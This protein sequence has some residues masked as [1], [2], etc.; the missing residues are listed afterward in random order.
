MGWTRHIFT[1]LN[2]NGDTPP[3]VQPRLGIWG[4]TEVPTTKR[5]RWMRLWVLLAFLAAF[6]AVLG[7]GYYIWRSMQGG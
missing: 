1:D 7:W 3:R 5:K 4:P 6:A 2:L